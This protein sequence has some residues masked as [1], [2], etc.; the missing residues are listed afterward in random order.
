MITPE[1]ESKTKSKS[2]AK[3]LDESFFLIIYKH[4]QNEYSSALDKQVAFRRYTGMQTSDERA[5]IKYI[6]EDING[7][8]VDVLLGSEDL[9]ENSRGSIWCFF[10]ADWLQ[11]L[12]TLDKEEPIKFSGKVGNYSNGIVYLSNCELE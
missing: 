7:R 9:Y 12:S 2:T 4:E 10:K 8:V 11:K 5:F 3:K 6:Q 1:I